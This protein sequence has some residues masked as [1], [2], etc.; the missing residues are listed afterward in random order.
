[1]YD[2][3]FLGKSDFMGALQFPLADIQETEK[4]WFSLN[5]LRKNKKEK[6]VIGE[7]QLGF[8]FAK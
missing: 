2:K 1:M 8:E 6:R 3:D 4:K 7:L 5:G